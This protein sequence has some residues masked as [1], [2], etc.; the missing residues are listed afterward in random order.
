VGDVAVNGRGIWALLLSDLNQPEV[1]RIDPASHRV[2]A[3]IPLSGG[4]G[5]YVFAIGGSVLAAVAQPPGGPYDGGTLVR[6]DGSTNEVTGTFDLG[7]YPSLAAGNNGIWAI[8][9]RGLMRI[10][11]RLGEPSGD[12]ENVSC[13]GD[14]LAVGAGGVWCFDPVSNRAL[15]RFNTTTDRVDVAMRPDQRSGGTALATSPGSVWVVNGKQLIR[16]DLG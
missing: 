8:T 10:D 13:T 9:D 3:R 1:L 15:T 11:P 2:L 16:I 7:G 12:P 5:R 14:A 6:I 4:V